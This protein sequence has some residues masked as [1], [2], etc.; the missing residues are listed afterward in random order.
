MAETVS[1]MAVASN[2]VVVAAAPA[3]ATMSATTWSPATEIS[4]VVDTTAGMPLLRPPAVVAA[5][6]AMVPA[7]SGVAAT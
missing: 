2:M 7:V 4:V 1:S 3:E 6:M 5:F